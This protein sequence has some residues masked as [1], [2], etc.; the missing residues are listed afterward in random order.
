MKL[1]IIVPCFNEQNTIDKIINKILDLKIS[2]EKELIIVDDSS[3][4]K[5][6]EILNTKFSR[7]RAQ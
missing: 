2:A 1:S 3:K 4:D 7:N 6:K 5:T